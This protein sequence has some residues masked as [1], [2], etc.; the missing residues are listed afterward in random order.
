VPGALGVVVVS[1]LVVAFTR[2]GHPRRAAAAAHHRTAP[3]G[4]AATKGTETT[5]TTP[6]TATPKNSS[7]SS[8]PVASGATTPIGYVSKPYAT[9]TAALASVGVP[10]NDPR[11]EIVQSPSGTQ[12]WAIEPEAITVQGHAELAMA[13]RIPDGKWE[14]WT[15]T[16]PGGAPSGVPFAL[17]DVANIGYNLHEGTRLGGDLMGT[18]PWGSVTGTVSRPEGWSVNDANP[19]RNGGHTVVFFVD[20]EE[21]TS[22]TFHGSYGIEISFDKENLTTGNGAILEIEGISTPATTLAQQATCTPPAGPAWCTTA[23]A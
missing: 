13:W 4:S 18:L 8:P 10:S 17:F 1:L 22:S 9:P 15:T 2:S 14:A 20:T 19:G 11:V 6:T 21:N 7:S 5:H 23:P 12:K 16:F 3:A